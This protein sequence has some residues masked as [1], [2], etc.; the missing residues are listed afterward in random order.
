MLSILLFITFS[1]LLKGGNL[2]MSNFVSNFVMVAL[3]RLMIFIFSFTSSD[4]LFLRFPKCL[5]VLV[6]PKVEYFEYKCMMVKTNIFNIWCKFV[7]C[8]IEVTYKI[9]ILGWYWNINMNST[10]LKYILYTHILSLVGKTDNLKELS[11]FCH[12]DIYYDWLKSCLNL[13]S[14]KFPCQYYPVQLFN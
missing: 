13:Q 1:I 14:M 9:Q 3:V 12:Y 8:E 5:C 10:L 7:I 2:K 11:N 4:V 6:K